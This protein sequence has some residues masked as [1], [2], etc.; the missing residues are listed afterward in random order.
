[1]KNVITGEYEA[2]NYVKN[3]YILKSA[4]FPFR[5]AICNEFGR[6]RCNGVSVPFIAFA[7]HLEQKHSW[8][9]DEEKSPYR[10]FVYAVKDDFCMKVFFK[11]FVIYT[12]LI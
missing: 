11:V 4:V 12:Y 10:G 2:W 1:M 7:K 3:S 5:A 8:I 9:K 6:E